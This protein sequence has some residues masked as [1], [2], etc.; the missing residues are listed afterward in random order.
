MTL[1]Y[2]A[3]ESSPEATPIRVILVDDHPLL[4]EGTRALLAQ[5][6]GIAVVGAAGDGKAALRLVGEQHPDVLL[7][8]IHLPDISG[9]EVA[10]EV[11][12]R[13]PRVA[14][15]VLTGYE[16]VGYARGLLQL[17]V[18]GYLRKS[19]SGAEIVAA[20]R[21]VAAGQTVLAPAVTR[22]V[23]AN[24]VDPLTAREY[25]V[26]GL[27]ARGQRNA[28][29]ARTLAVSVKTVEFH[30]SHVL[31]KLGVRS[32]TEAILKARQQGFALPE[33]AWASEP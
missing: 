21:A 13:S 19:A 16:D 2:A 26:L 18:Q 22:V 29:I 3:G 1:P 10:R 23:I 20:I 11:R 5:N 14:I 12:V 6:A 9:V 33:T 32:R 4:R 17:G 24:G 27:L 7:L 15:L 25:E 8:D 31:D 28:E 30:I